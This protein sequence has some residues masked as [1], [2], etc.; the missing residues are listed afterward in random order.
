MA[1]VCQLLP[2]MVWPES[3]Q[4]QRTS[5]L[6]LAGHLKLATLAPL[7]YQFA[8]GALACDDARDTSNLVDL[9]RQMHKVRGV[10]VIPRCS[11]CSL[12]HCANLATYK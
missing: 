7:V 8:K 10:A 5:T 1:P 3:A 4:F 9:F 6:S 2:P 11:R 12:Q